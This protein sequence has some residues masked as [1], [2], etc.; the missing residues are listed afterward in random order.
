MCS[1][2]RK[3]VKL[4]ECAAIG[5]RTHSHV[6]AYARALPRSTVIM[7]LDED[8]AARIAFETIRSW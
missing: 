4:A 8:G 2:G 3:S 1:R 7:T 5:P 6:G